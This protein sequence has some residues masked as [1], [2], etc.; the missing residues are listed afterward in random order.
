MDILL[1]LGR[2][3]IVNKWGLGRLM[4][5]I[6]G[7]VNPSSGAPVVVAGVDILAG[8]S[9]IWKLLLSVNI[10]MMAPCETMLREYPV[11]R[12]EDMSEKQYLCFMGIFFLAPCDEAIADALA[13]L[14]DWVEHH[15]KHGGGL[16]L[17]TAC[18]LCIYLK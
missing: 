8:L 12:V 16:I 1:R 4:V 13:G 14:E 10:C 2:W 15:F 18:L 5:G 3:I 9:K 6:Y 17:H 11:R 7:Q